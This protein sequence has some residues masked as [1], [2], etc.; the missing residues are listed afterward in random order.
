MPLALLPNPKKRDSD[1]E[2]M[3]EGIYKKIAA[4]SQDKSTKQ[5]ISSDKE[6]LSSSISEISQA[7]IIDQAE[8]LSSLSAIE[9]EEFSDALGSSE[10]A[11]KSEMNNQVFGKIDKDAFKELYDELSF[12]FGKSVPKDD[13]INRCS[14]N[15][16]SVVFDE[17]YECI[18]QEKLGHDVIVLCFFIQKLIN[19]VKLIMIFY[20]K[21]STFCYL[22]LRK[23]S[24]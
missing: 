5:N 2:I 10:A 24:F 3:K 20:G 4:I 8:Y 17:N 1:D 7:E 15:L 6:S 14:I 9:E 22:I 13:N 18:Y 19:L 16:N 23:R 12:S 11:R 21:F